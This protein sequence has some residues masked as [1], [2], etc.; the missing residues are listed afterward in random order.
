MR[1]YKIDAERLYVAGFSGGSRLA[2]RLALAYPDLFTGALLDAGSDPIG[3]SVVPLPTRDLLYTF[4]SSSRIVYASGARDPDRAAEDQVSMR[5]MRHW[6][7]TNLESFRQPLLAHE[8]L[9]A[10]AFA[11]ALESLMQRSAP[12]ATHLQA[13]R[14][15]IERELE[16][17]AGH[18]RKLKA[19]GNQNRLTQEIEDLNDRFGGLATTVIEELMLD[20]SSAVDKLGR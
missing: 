7:M 19:D 14:A 3:N 4:Q 2:M 13:C 15:H 18:A 12:D 1:R 20:H 6:C 11:R 17:R 8:V 10:P 16:S 9:P 5:S